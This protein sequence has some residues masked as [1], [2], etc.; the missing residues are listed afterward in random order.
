MISGKYYCIDAHCHVF[1]DKVVDRAV[2][3]I[4]NFYHIPMYWRGTVDTLIK[5]GDDSGIDHF[6]IHSVATKP[7]QVS[8]ANRYLSSVVADHP[9]RMTGLGT[10]HPL[11]SDMERDIDELVSLGLHGIKIHPD[12]Q[13]FAL[14]C[15]GFMRAYEI[16]Q[17][18]GLPVLAHT[19]DDRGDCTNPDRVEHVL[20]SFPHLTFVGAHFG[21]YTV[22]DWAAEVL[23]K[24]DNLFVDTWSTLFW[25][26]AWGMRD[27]I[28]KYGIDRCMFGT[29]FPMHPASLE[30]KA[31][32][33]LGYTDEEY[34]KLF[35]E[36]ARRIY[37][38]T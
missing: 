17:A 33:Y 25:K 22:W 38:I 34:N 23:P 15:D 30:L 32:L 3:A 16:C 36:N 1:P 10:I 13:G 9:G 12:M 14:D 5:S 28:G 27:L 29:D 21:G 26:G 20:Q 24:Y 35:S 8:S 6:L 18:K 7:E 31:L 37:D 2:G 11:S 4:G 19:G